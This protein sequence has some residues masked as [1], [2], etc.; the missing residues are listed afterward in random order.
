MSGAAAV[1]LAPSFPPLLR[2]VTV[3]AGA[4]PVAAAVTAMAEG[5]DPGQV[6]YAE[7]DDTLRA[8][9]TLAPEE[10]VERAARAGFAV[11]LGLS[12]ALGALAPPEVA[13]QFDWPGGIRVN[14]AACGAV[15]LV[16]PPTAPGAVPDWLVAGIEIAVAAAPGAAD[17]G[18]A[19]DRTT[20]HDEGC[21]EIT[22]PA[23]I[24]SWSRHMLVWIHRYLSDGFAPLQDGWTGRWAAAG[25]AVAHPAAGTAV[26]LDEDGGLI[27]RDAA[28]GTA[29]HPLWRQIEEAS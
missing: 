25:T 6:F 8:A 11:M 18:H 24:E 4:D 1:S 21:A 22:V 3:P 10:P 7:T 2:G 20:L 17:P 27:L 13:V 19:P 23:L 12:D 15:R 29:I 16:G 28:G 5:G 9:V 14:G 26:G